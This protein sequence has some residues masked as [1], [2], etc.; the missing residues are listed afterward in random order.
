MN[1]VTMGDAKYFQ[2]ILLSVTQ[3]ARYYPERK[4]FLYDWGFEPSQLEQLMGFL[5]VEV[6]NW[7]DRLINAD[8]VFPEQRTFKAFI[9]KHILRHP[10]LRIPQRQWQREFLLDEKCYCMLDAVFRT[11]ASFL[12]LDGDAFIVNHVDDLADADSDVVVTLR[13][14]EEIEAARKRGSRHDINSGVILF[15]KNKAKTIAFI[16]E[17]IKANCL[18][19]CHKI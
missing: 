3:S 15:G 4:F 5:G 1:F 17:W 7:R 2:T 8:L 18:S 14:L 13:P 9:K 12:F 16:I 6:I 11:D 19:F 10:N